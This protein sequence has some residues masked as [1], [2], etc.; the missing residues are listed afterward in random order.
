LHYTVL[1]LAV[2]P[3]GEGAPLKCFPVAIVPL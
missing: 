3:L 2:F 1:A